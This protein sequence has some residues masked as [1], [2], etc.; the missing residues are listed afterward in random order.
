[1]PVLAKFGG[2]VIRLMWLGTL[3]ARLHVFYGGS[4]MVVDLG[5]MQ[6]LH[7]D[8]PEQ[9]TQDALRWLWANTAEL[10]AALR[11]LPPGHHGPEAAA[12]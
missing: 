8:L 9:A 2:M 7:N 5:R 11:N 3:G 6:V 4:E 1:M 12:A 10:Q